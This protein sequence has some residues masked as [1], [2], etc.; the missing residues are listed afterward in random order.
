MSVFQDG[1]GHTDPD[2]YMVSEKGAVFGEHGALEAH[3]PGGYMRLPGAP[4]S[5]YPPWCDWV[6][7][8][9]SFMRAAG[10]DGAQRAQL[11]WER[12][13]GMM[14]APGVCSFHCALPA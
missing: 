12:C 4:S 1:R 11:G 13:E 10:W 7:P 5:F 14:P 9:L 3:P 8:P 6:Q 2:S